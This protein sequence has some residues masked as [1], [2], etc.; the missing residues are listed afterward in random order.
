MP[1]YVRRLPGEKSALMDTKAYPAH[2][3]FY[4]PSASENYIY[5]RVTEHTKNSMK[6][7]MVMHNDTTKQTYVV[8]TP[9][10]KLAPTMNLF[11]GIEDLRLCMFKDRLWF[12]AATTHAS[13][14]MSNELLLGYFNAAVTEI[15][16]LTVLDIGV[17]PVKNVCPFVHDSCL[18]LFDMFQQKI[19]KVE[20]DLEAL[21]EEEKY[22]AVTIKTLEFANKIPLEKYRGST[23]PVHLHGNTWGCVVHDIIFNDTPSI[24][25]RCSY[26]HH[27]VEFDMDRGMITFISRPFFVAHWGIEYISGIQY[28]NGK[29]LLYIGIDDKQPL[30]CT[31]T[32]AH[33]RVGK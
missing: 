32:L 14:L 2:V 25:M 27:W 16:Y 17:L 4:N 26:L 12:T 31:T 18:L 20:T 33:L 15:E 30:L 23:S 8:E 29:V 13:D 9:W 21:D 28:K 19:Y 22:V 24:M 7:K 3:K 10:D 6:N 5:I 1:L 11:Q